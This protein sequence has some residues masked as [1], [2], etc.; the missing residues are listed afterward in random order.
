MDVLAVK[1]NKGTVCRLAQSEG[2]FEH[3]VEY[4]LK[5]ARRGVDD[6]QDLGGRGLL[7]QCLAGLGNEPGVFDRD[8]GLVGKGADQLDLP[9]GKRLDPLPTNPDDPDRLALAQQ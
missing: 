4:R 7:L 1:S 8:D 6:L 5:V 2:L 3:R 9:L